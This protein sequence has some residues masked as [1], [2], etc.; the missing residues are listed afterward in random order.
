YMGVGNEPDCDEGEMTCPPIPLS[1]STLSFWSPLPGF[2]TVAQD[3]EL[4]NVV[5]GADQFLQDARAGTLPAVSW[6]IPANQVS[7]HPPNGVG[8][9]QA[10][11]T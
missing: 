9:G 5:Q 10:Y 4:G 7:D 1:P 3:G 8:E 2:V 6:V 11:V